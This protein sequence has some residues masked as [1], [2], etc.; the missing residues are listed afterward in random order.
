MFMIPYTLFL[1]YLGEIDIMCFGYIFC[2]LVFV[3]LP[4]LRKLIVRKKIGKE[5]YFS[6]FQSIM[7]ALIHVGHSFAVF[8]GMLRFVLRKI[9]KN[10]KVFAASSV[11]S[12]EYS[13]KNAVWLMKQFALQNKFFLLVY[14]LCFERICYVISVNDI[15]L[16]AKIV[17]IYILGGTIV[18]PFI[19]T[20]L[21]YHTGSREELSRNEIILLISLMLYSLTKNRVRRTR[22]KATA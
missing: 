1:A 9:I 3:L 15:T 12:I 2:R 13:F 19:C 4:P 17:S 11:G 14:L 22:R 21:F 18:A 8:S 20:P 10:R 7:S 16:F 5:Y 6:L